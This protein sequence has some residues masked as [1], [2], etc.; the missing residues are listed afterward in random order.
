MYRQSIT[1]LYNFIKEPLFQIP[2]QLATGIDKYVKIVYFGAT[3]TMGF[4][5]VATP[6]ELFQD[7]LLLVFALNRRILG[8]T[9]F[10]LL[11]FFITT[12]AM[13][14]IMLMYFLYARKWIPSGICPLL[15]LY[16]CSIWLSPSRLAEAFERNYTLE[17]FDSQVRKYKGLYILVNLW[18]KMYKWIIM[19]FKFCMV[20]GSATLLTL[21]IR[22]G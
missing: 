4:L 11:A 2:P 17:K 16:C 6:L 3:Y 14:Y 18:S 20:M 12:A 5:A 8:M 21:S 15:I 7:L 19:T 22:L 13:A 10:K 1:Y 9:G